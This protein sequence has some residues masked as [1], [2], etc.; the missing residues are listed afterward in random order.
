MEDIRQFA[1]NVET[2]IDGIT[3]DE[4]VNDIRVYYSVM[5]NVELIGEAANMLTRVLGKNI[6][7]CHGD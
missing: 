4:F 1:I 3:Y 7:N 5:K 6:R 2:I